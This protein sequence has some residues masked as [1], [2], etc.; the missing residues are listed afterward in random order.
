MMR[1]IED[2]IGIQPSA[3]IADPEN[4][5]GL[6]RK[7]YRLRASGD[8]PSSAPVPQKTVDHV[9]GYFELSDRL[10]AEKRIRLAAARKRLV[11]LGYDPDK[12]DQLRATRESL[13]A[14]SREFASLLDSSQIIADLL[15][16]GIRTEEAMLEF[17]ET[18]MDKK[19][20]LDKR[21]AALTEF[22]RV[23]EGFLSQ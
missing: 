23:K 7:Y 15:E 9:V 22:L 4:P 6:R 21:I 10:E 18:A 14:E 16:K 2:G 17:I 12:E 13:M 5:E 3:H 1:M 8:L 19:E 11:A 20:K